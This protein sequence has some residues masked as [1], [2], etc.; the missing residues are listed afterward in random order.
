MHAAKRHH[1]WTCGTVF[2][3]I[4]CEGYSQAKAGMCIDMKTFIMRVKQHMDRAR[5]R[6]KYFGVFGNRENKIEKG[7]LK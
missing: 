6:Y 5:D 7:W 1:E 4:S 2:R 3:L